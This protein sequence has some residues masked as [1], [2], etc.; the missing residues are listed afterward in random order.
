MRSKKNNYF[1]FPREE[2]NHIIETSINQPIHILIKKLKTFFPNITNW[3]EINS[4]K[5]I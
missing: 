4:I 3:N 1:I 2:M 5:F